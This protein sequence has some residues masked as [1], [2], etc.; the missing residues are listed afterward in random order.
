MKD[1]DKKGREM[2]KNILILCIFLGTL[3]LVAK[4]SENSYYKCTV[5]SI[6]NGTS[7]IIVSIQ[8]A[9]DMNQHDMSLVINNKE[10]RVGK[11][12]RYNFIRNNVIQNINVDVYGMDVY[13]S[14]TNKFFNHF[15]IF[16]FP[17]TLNLY[18]Y[19]FYDPNNNKVGTRVFSCRKPSFIEETKMKLQF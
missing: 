10:L 14:K 8:E 16:L 17:R 19:D 6:G 7:R 2:I 3:N 11:T 12:A 18:F 13:D 1:L 5:S 4:D 9:K 15:E